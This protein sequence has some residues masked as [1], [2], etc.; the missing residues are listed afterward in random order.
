MKGIGVQGGEEGIL[1]RRGMAWGRVSDPSGRVK[2]VT[3][4]E[5]ARHELSEPEQGEGDIYTSRWSGIGK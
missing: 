4:Q 1:H 3:T 2:R 5:E